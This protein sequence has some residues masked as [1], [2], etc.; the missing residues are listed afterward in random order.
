M[1]QT[2]FS[3]PLAGL[4]R[5][6][7]GGGR[8]HDY[9]EILLIGSGARVI[10]LA[11][12]FLVLLILSHVLPKGSFG[13]LMTAFGFYRLASAALGV[14]GSLVLLFHISRH[15]NDKDA[16][17]KLHRYAAL[18]GAA[19]SAFVAVAGFLGAGTIATA[20]GK[21]GLEVWFH[22][23]A[24]FAVFNTLLIVST[25]AL[26]GRSRVSES[27]ALCEV[28]PNLVR[29]ALLPLVGWL[30][31]PDVYV[32]HA[33]TL[34]VIIPWLWPAQR[35]RDRS[36]AGMRPWTA[37]DHNYCIKSAVG[38]LFANQLGAVDILVGGA[39]FSSDV[40]ADYAVA[41]R[42]AGLFTFLQLAVLKRFAPRAGRLIQTGETG[43]LRQ[44][45]ELCRQLMIALAAMSVCGILLTAPY[46]LPLFGNYGGALHL[47]YW[48]A[49]PAYVGAFYA[50]S[51]RLLTIA[52]H[53]GIMLLFNGLSFLVLITL[54][55]AA[56]PW[57]GVIAIPTAMILSTLVFNLI[58][59]AR[60][61]KMFGIR[62]IRWWDAAFMAVGTV[63]LAAAAIAGTTPAEIAASGVLACIGLYFAS[64]AMGWRGGSQIDGRV[65]AT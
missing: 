32:A 2:G 62:T 56:A 63:A 25:G 36:V 33:L 38:M 5:W 1:T 4:A 42:I 23:L 54:P 26:E 29:V 46:V 43:L 8:F 37:W 13:D 27:I 44:E 10:G 22:E 52:G 55:F 58:I 15:P 53:A 18:L 7:L 21:P 61:Q 34:S 48:L 60:V 31:L 41:S 24:P 28:A 59:T 51:D 35:L 3:R 45:V 9:L 11:S 19:V 49:I 6:G 40:V 14:G 64:S 17:I 12:Q 16:E 57:I 20:L 47:L 65:Q 30:H 50:T 39:L